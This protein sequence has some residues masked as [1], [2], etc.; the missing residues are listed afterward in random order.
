[1]QT[2]SAYLW[3]QIK[4]LLNVWEDYVVP[5]FSAS[6]KHPMHALVALQN[7]SFLLCT[8]AYVFLQ[9]SLKALKR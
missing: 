6:D 5:F 2:P 9:T 4:R 3:K 7:L 8:Q 1:M